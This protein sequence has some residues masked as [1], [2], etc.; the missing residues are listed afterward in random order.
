[1]LRI[2]HINDRDSVST[3]RL[4]G[5]LQGL[6]V[7]ELARSCE[8][9]PCFPDRLSLDL[10]GVTFVDGPGLAVLSDLLG[11]GVTLSACSGFVAELLHKETR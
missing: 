11:H 5:K 2:T 6:W 4:E 7:A 8:E 10:A 1:M 3:L 9:L